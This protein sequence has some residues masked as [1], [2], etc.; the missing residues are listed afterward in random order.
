MFVYKFKLYFFIAAFV[1]QFVASLELY[2]VEFVEDGM[3]S[4]FL[5]EGVASVP[6]GGSQPRHFAFNCISMTNNAEGSSWSRKDGIPLAKTQNIIVNG[7]QLDLENAASS[8]L[9]VYGWLYL[10]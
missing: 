4:I 10:S 1:A 9:T 8:D 6:I 5:I 7:V 2:Q 3:N